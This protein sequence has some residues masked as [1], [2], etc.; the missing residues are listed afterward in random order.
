MKHVISTS[1]CVRGRVQGRSNQVSKISTISFLLMQAQ[2]LTQELTQEL[3]ATRV[4]SLPFSVH[5]CQLSALM[6][7]VALS[8]AVSTLVG[9]RPALSHRA[10]SRMIG[11]GISRIRSRRM[12]RRRLWSAFASTLVARASGLIRGLPVLIN[13]TPVSLTLLR[14]LI[15]SFSPATRSRLS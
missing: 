9:T 4:C 10:I 13:I 2:E 15:L 6:L 1:F 5:L 12:S 14:S 8:P 7:V 3:P 11:G